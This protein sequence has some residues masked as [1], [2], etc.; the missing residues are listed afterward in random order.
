M[1]VALAFLAALALP[2]AALA[3]GSAPIT[4]TPLLP[5]PTT[6]TP[7]SAPDAAQQTPPPR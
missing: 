3:Q 6:D 5:P 1:K 2:I 4:A 7:P